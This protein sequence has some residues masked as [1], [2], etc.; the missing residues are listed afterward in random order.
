MG[1]K[2]V[3]EGAMGNWVQRRFVG[4]EAKY[5]PE[6]T[7]KEDGD[8]VVDPSPEKHNGGILPISHAS[9]ANRG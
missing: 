2:V 3:T 6:E 8:L 9:V 4:V 5:A 7:E 1:D